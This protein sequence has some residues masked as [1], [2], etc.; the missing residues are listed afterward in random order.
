MAGT[1]VMG[2]I[3]NSVITNCDLP[4]LSNITGSE[5]SGSSLGYHGFSPSLSSI[6]SCKLYSS[7]IYGI[8][9]DFVFASNQCNNIRIYIGA[10]FSS[11]TNA[12][13]VGNQFVGLYTGANDVIIIDPS[14][15]SYKLYTIQNNTF[16]MQPANPSCI[17]VST[18]EGNPLGYGFLNI[19]GNTFWRSAS[20]LSYSTNMKVNYSQNVSFG[21]AH[22]VGGG[23]LGVNGN[24]SY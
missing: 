2:N 18:N 21:V 19:Q 8:S 12:N 22:P 16:Q 23:G 11:P 9:N 15:T 5:I 1:T 4:K 24:F 3:S 13:V 7:R 6:T 20:T 14:N 17:A 10:G